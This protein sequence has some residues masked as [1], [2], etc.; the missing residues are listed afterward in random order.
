MGK[1]GLT[2]INRDTPEDE[3]R[4]GDV[5]IT[6]LRV[7]GVLSSNGSTGPAIPVPDARGL[8]T[9]TF[10]YSVY[11]HKGD[12]KK[13]QS[14]KQGYELY[15]QGYEFNYDL[16]GKQIPRNKKYRSQRSFVSIE[17]NNV[18]MTAMK[19]VEDRDGIILFYE[20]SG[21]E[22]DTTIN[23]FDN[24]QKVVKTNLIEEELKK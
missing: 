15:K 6:L 13:A 4:D 7:V 8:K 10:R 24:P 9:Y 16:I 5:Y 18:I 17:P 12:W 14:Y 3:V 2:V 19:P 23:L 21:E 20:A 22:T 11:P 1:K